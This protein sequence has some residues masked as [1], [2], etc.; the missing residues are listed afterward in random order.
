MPPVACIYGYRLCRNLY[1]DDGTQDLKKRSSYDKRQVIADLIDRLITQRR[2]L[3]RGTFVCADSFEFF[4][5]PLETEH[6]VC[7][8]LAKSWKHQLNSEPSYGREKPVHST[9]SRLR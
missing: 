2:R 7:L 5:S 8:S 4:P 6:G 3:Q 1:G 9:D